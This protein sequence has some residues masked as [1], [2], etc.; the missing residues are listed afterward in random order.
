MANT[1]QT[2][3]P[4]GFPEFDRL[5]VLIR[6]TRELLDFVAGEG[7]LPDGGVSYLTE[8]TLPHLE[9]VQSGFVGWLRSEAAGADELRYLIARVAAIRVDP[10]QNDAERRAAVAESIVEH[11]VGGKSARGSRTIRIAASWDLA[12][13]AHARLVLAVIPRIPEAAVRFPAGR[14]SYADI[15]TPRGP[16][17]LSERIS[18]LERQLWMA[19]TGRPS[20][21][22]DPA[23]RRTYGF[24]DAAD[25]LGLRAFGLAA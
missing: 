11:R 1:G 9:D 21:P 13:L 8:Q 17:E 14:R 25:R 4:S 18:E 15:P 20:S 5:L 24:F 12:A 22:T 6:R 3:E 16:A 10:P 23:F 19:A 7:G 2:I